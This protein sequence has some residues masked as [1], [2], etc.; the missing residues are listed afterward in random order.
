MLVHPTLLAR[1]AAIEQLGGYRA[2][3]HEDL[4][5]WLRACNAGLR[6]VRG[7]TPGLLYRRHPDQVTAPGARDARRPDALVDAEYSTLFD[8]LLGSKLDS[9]PF[10]AAATSGD[11]SG[12]D[13]GARAEFKRL[14][15]QKAR[16]FSV[17]QRL[18]LA[19]RLARI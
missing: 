18:L 4:D 7:G 13:E 12:I 9:R 5:L 1:R 15:R 10:R 11:R 2:T 17:A 19:F 14:V 16:G 6:I 8:R 3:P